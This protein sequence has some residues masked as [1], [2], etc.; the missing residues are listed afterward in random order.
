[1]I[2]DNTIINLIDFNDLVVKCKLSTYGC[3]TQGLQP[4]P[5]RVDLH[6]AP[7][8]DNYWLIVVGD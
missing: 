1:M 7:I 2:S 8:V 5:S 6:T 4:G 3:V